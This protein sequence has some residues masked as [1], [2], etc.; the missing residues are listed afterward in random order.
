[1]AEALE[2][3]VS[4]KGILE[5]LSKV[6]DGLTM[7]DSNRGPKTW[8]PAGLKEA[9]DTLKN[10]IG[11]LA[12]VVE[13]DSVNVSKVVEKEI[14]N[15]DLKQQVREHSDEIDKQQ[16]KNLLGKIVI[17]STKKGEASSH[18]KSKETL[19]RQDISLK[20]HVVELTKVKYNLDILEDDIE[21]CFHLPKG[22]IMVSFWKKSRGSPFQ[23]LAGMIKSKTNADLNLYFNFCLTKRRSQLLFEV[24]KLKRDNKIDKFY[25]DEHG[26]ISIKLANSNFK[27]KVTS[28]PMKESS[29]LKTMTIEELHQETQPRQQ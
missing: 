5:K 24:R 13:K 23:E 25:S 10:V 14:E 11:D 21:T 16:Q 6:T 26:L 3:T 9:F 18:I 19:Q 8:A 2:E 29:N 27:Q 15:D 4:I 20:K 1:M 28:I 17:S 22:G 7:L 12:K